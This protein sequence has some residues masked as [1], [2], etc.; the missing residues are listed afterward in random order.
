MYLTFKIDN[1]NYIREPFISVW[2][3]TIYLWDLRVSNRS[4]LNL[5][6]LIAGIRQKISPRDWT[7]SKVN[8]LITPSLFHFYLHDLSNINTFL[9]LAIAEKDKKLLRLCTFQ[10]SKL[11]VF[12]CRKNDN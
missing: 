9:K 8:P 11:K 5:L 6:F 1:M 10:I 12:E 3:H 2:K 4:T 7:S